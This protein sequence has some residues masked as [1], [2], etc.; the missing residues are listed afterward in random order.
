MST[1]VAKESTAP[2]QSDDAQ[3]SASLYFQAAFCAAVS[4]VV[5]V[6]VIAGYHLLMQSKTK[7]GMIDVAALLEANEV[8]F[9]ERI[10]RP[11][12]TEADKE[13]AMEFARQTGPKIERAVFDI[14]QECKCLLLA[15]AAVV[16]DTAIDYTPRVKAAIGMESVDVAQ[17]QERIRNRMKVS[18][19]S[20]SNA[21]SASTQP[22]PRADHLKGGQ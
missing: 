18:T 2:N 20:G 8:M 4:L 13:Q 3:S 15:K 12:V 14:Q 11:N 6:L 19:D 21:A 7:T 22:A 10:S 5:C 17:L 9:T 16:G 1:D